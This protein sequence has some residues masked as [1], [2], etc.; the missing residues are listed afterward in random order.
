MEFLNEN[1]LSYLEDN[2]PDEPELLKELNRVTNLKVPYPNMLTGHVQGRFLAFMSKLL[3]PQKILEIGTYTG[4]SAICFAEGLA[5]GGEIHTIDKNPEVEDI[6][7]EYFH[8]AGLENT[9][10][11]HQ[12]DALKILPELKGSFDIIFLDADKENYPNYLPLCK[13]KLSKKGLLMVDNTLWSGKVLEKV[14]TGDFETRG[15]ATFNKM[16]KED[17]ELESL[18]LPL[19]DGITFIRH[20]SPKHQEF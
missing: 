15:I 13:E 14:H 3:R 10:T 8:R 16:V 1:I 2:Y 4:Y 20:A 12:G 7:V 6:A 18:I 19:R 9:I 11:R 5:P 17:P